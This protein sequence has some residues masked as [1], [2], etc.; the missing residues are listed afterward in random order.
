MDNSGFEQWVYTVE[1]TGKIL[2]L[3]PIDKFTQ[4]FFRTEWNAQLIISTKETIDL[5]YIYFVQYGIVKINTQVINCKVD[6]KQRGD[7][8]NINNYNE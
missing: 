1:D 8:R 6:F 5:I 3:E 2:R 7:T 4:D